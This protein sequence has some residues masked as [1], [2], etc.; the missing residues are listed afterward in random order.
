M[1]PVSIVEERAPLVPSVTIRIAYEALRPRVTI[2]CLAKSEWARLVD[3]VTAS[4]L[5]AMLLNDPLDLACEKRIS[6]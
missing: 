6:W 2:D 4:P 5:L 3:W 1:A